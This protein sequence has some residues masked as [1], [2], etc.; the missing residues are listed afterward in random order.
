MFEITDDE[1]REALVKLLSRTEVDFHKDN[2]LWIYR[3]SFGTWW[4]FV[5]V[6]EGGNSEWILS[7]DL[8]GPGGTGYLTYNP[9][10]QEDYLLILHRC[11]KILGIEEVALIPD[12]PILGPLGIA[13]WLAS[14]TTVVS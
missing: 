5:V 1:L 8:D 12:T 11:L 4:I 9:G 13:A 14:N 2:K 3:S 6:K 10:M 7:Y